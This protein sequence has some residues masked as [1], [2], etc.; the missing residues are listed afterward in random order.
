MKELC[1]EV[2]ATGRGKTR[3]QRTDRY[4][5]SPHER[6]ESKAQLAFHQCQNQG[7]QDARYN[8]EAGNNQVLNRLSQASPI[9]RPHIGLARAL[10]A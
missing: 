5:K 6:V 3:K 4:H 9:L 7:S 1:P 10:P 8:P 2:V